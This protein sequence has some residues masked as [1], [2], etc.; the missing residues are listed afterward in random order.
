MPAIE[1][2]QA[3]Y[4]RLMAFKPVVEEAIQAKLAEV[5][6]MDFITFCA[7]ERL[8]LEAAMSSDLQVMEA[9]RRGDTI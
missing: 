1:I 3:H 6:F 2:T 5:E 8:F 9:V 7:V 4:D